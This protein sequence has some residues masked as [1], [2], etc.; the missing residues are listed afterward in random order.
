[1]SEYRP[2]DDMMPVSVDAERAILGAIL[3]DNNCFYDQI[4]DLSTDDFSLSSHRRIFHVMNEI[5]SGNIPD[6]RQ[7]DF[8]TISGALRKDKE[9]DN[10]GGVSYL[11]SLTEG[12]PRRMDVSNYVKIVKDKAK[13]RRIYS[14]C[15]SAM[16]LAV[17][18]VDKPSDIISK[19]ESSLLEVSSEGE[20]HIASIG[21]I[22]VE[23]G[24]WSRA[25]V[26]K[27]RS[28]LEYTWG[29][30][31]IDDFTHGMFKG[32]FSVVSG[33]ASG[34]K[35]AF[36]CQI[37]LQNALESTPVGIMS[38]EMEGPQLKRRLYSILGDA[39]TSSHMR[40]PRTMGEAQ[41]NEVRNATK[42]LAGLPIY[43][44]DRRRVRID[45]LLSRMRM[46]RRKYGCKIFIVD[47]LQLIRQM[48]GMSGIDAF[49]EVVFMLRDFPTIEPDT[50]LIALS[51]YS[52]GSKMQRGRRTREDLYGGAVIGQAAQNVIMIEMEDTREIPSNQLVDTS[53]IFD[54]QREG[55]RGRVTAYFDRDH[56]SFCQAQP[57]MG[58]M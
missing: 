43:I 37:A 35:T 28:S 8:I 2:S 27:D 15:S 20:S 53:F 34:G 19:L 32:E 11:A 31:E 6:V 47:Y 7:A 51:Q 52:K 4:I 22:D 54:K 18:Q 36:A 57:T 41:K 1:M 39:L 40:D 49:N 50:H 24:L 5:L 29:V 25:S 30:K 17:D 16:S 48:P 58:G 55:K 45:Q 14:I 10:V 3:L 13:L 38:M 21:E 56:M 23:S 26:D 9:I 12:L 46:M 33:E 42:I 44:D